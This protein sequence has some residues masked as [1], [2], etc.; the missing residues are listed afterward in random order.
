M[1]KFITVADR[2]FEV[3]G[4]GEHDDGPAVREAIAYASTLGGNNVV[5]F[6]AGEF[7]CAPNYGKWRKDGIKIAGASVTETILK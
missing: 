1:A 4:D 5:Q 3:V 7:W 6:P 2:K